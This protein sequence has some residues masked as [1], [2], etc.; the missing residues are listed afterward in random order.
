[1]TVETRA[2]LCALLAGG[3]L[4]QG[5]VQVLFRRWEMGMRYGGIKLAKP[6]NYSA[7]HPQLATESGV[8]LRVKGVL[9][10]VR[11]LN[12]GKPA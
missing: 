10:D 4:E 11:L 12:R 2:Q 9:I 7:K 1:M 6:P 8:I 5:V 3:L